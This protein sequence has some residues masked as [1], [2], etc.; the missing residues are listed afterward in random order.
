MTG[1][2]ALTGQHDTLTV[3]E[4]NTIWLQMT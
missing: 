2:R 3:T 1:K 4:Q